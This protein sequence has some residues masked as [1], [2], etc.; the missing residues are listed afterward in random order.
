[1]CTPHFCFTCMY[2]YLM[3][4]TQKHRHTWVVAPKVATKITT[5]WAVQVDISLTPCY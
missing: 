1:M 5:V 4:Y 3:S 2:N